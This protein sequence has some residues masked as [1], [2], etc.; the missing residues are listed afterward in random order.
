MLTRKARERSRMAGNAVP[1]RGCET[2]DGDA[3][4]AATPGRRD[5]SGVRQGGAGTDAGNWGR[6][7]AVDPVQ[8]GQRWRTVPQYNRGGGGETQTHNRDP[9]YAASGAKPIRCE[10]TVRT[11]ARTP[12][13]P[14]YTTSYNKS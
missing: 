12:P 7:E 14:G 9:S 6:R 2:A 1:G 13:P 8:T 5:G 3:S 10:C 4:F 11:A